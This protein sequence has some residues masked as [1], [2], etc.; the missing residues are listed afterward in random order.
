VAGT[1]TTTTTTKVTLDFPTRA[2]AI[3]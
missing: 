3:P 2:D 1:T